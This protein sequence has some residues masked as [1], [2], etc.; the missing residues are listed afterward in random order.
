MD[1]DVNLVSDDYVGADGRI[2]LYQD[3]LKISFSTIE[4]IQ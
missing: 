4:T 1:K 2:S 3:N